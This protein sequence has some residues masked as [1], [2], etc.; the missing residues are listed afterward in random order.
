MGVERG[1]GLGEH[2]DTMLSYAWL[3]ASSLRRPAACTKQRLTVLHWLA[4]KL[5]RQEARHAWRQE[6][7]MVALA[8]KGMTQEGN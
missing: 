5:L 8:L 4:G 7:E 6:C 2:T 3:T 1:S